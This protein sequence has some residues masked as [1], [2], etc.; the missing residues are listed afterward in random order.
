MSVA[1]MTLMGQT[2]ARRMCGRFMTS[3]FAATRRFR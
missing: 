3:S 2:P 1:A